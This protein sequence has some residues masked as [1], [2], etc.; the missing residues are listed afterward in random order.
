MLLVLRN[1]WALLL[2][3]GL[4]M[5]GNGMQG[6]L[7]GIRGALED[8][9]T[10]QMSVVMSCYFVGFLFGS[11]LAPDMIRRVGHVRVFAALGSMI[12]AVLVMYAAAPDWMVWAV[13]R[14]L[15]GFSFSGVYITT[16]SWLNNASTN[17]TRGQALS[18]YLIVQMI[19]IISAQMLLNVGDPSGF[20]L[21][22][23]PSV[24]VSLAFTPILLSVS[25]APAFETTKPLSFRRLYRASPLGCVGTF[26][27][28]G[29]FS[30]QFGMASV[31]GTQVGLS[32]RDLSIFVS[33][34]YVGGLVAQ[35]PIGWL[36]D[37]MDRRLL[38]L[39][40]SVFGAVALTL[41]ILMDLPFVGLI[42]IGAIGGAVSN[43][44]YSLLL[45]YVN[46]YLDRT[47]MAAASAGLMF[48]NGLGAISGPIITGWM[49]ETIGSAGFFLFMAILFAILAVYGAWRMTQRRGTPEAT[50]GFTPVSPT[51]SVVSVEAAAMVDAQDARLNDVTSEPRS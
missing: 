9:S 51:A 4:L 2:G 35:Y 18:L 45:A 44:L 36:S 11:R 37:R 13:L 46:D 12:S 48:I 20:I 14:V 39:W 23:I 26:L 28:G 27:M 19:G 1:T 49:M 25:Q 43:P 33:A 3:L 38:I 7:L 30:A 24:L 22:V 34:I 10:T 31:W 29:V 16:E 47:D 17:E 50:S 42:L 5:L 6:T 8:F 15:I 41:P 32:V 21:F 40:L